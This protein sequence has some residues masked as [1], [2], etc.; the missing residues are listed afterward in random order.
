MLSRG[1]GL[2]RRSQLACL[3]GVQSGGQ[4]CSADTAEY[5]ARSCLRRPRWARHRNQHL[6]TIRSC[7]ELGGTFQEHSRARLLGPGGDGTYRIL[8]DPAALAP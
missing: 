1:D 2:D 4:E 5:V 7:D 3:L 8:L 6:P